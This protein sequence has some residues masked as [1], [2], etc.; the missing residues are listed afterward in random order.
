M[1][2]MASS[3]EERKRVG[4]RV[5]ANPKGFRPRLIAYRLAGTCEAAVSPPSHKLS[6]K[7]N[8]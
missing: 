7:Q 5:T 6:N 4:E 1:G 8:A 2:G 3:F